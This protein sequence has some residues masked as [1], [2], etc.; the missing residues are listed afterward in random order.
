MLQ[1]LEAQN[2]AIRRDLVK[3]EEKM[4]RFENNYKNKSYHVFE[5]SSTVVDLVKLPFDHQ[6]PPIFEQSRR[7]KRINTGP[8]IED[9]VKRNK[10]FEN[11]IAKLEQE[12]QKATK[13]EATMKDK[14]AQANQKIVELEELIK[15]HISQVFRSS[16]RFHPQSED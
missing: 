7:L 9:L 13:R 2:K 3:F 11:K 6:E 15:I 4:T 5:A 10:E 16:N 12:D 14:L 8:S 1:K